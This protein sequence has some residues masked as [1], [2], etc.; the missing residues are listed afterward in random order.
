MTRKRLNIINRISLKKINRVLL[1]LNMKSLDMKKKIFLFMVAAAGLLS[2]H[3]CEFGSSDGTNP[4]VTDNVT[5]SG[6]VVESISGDPIFGATV[7]LTDGEEVVTTTTDVSGTYSLEIYIADD[8]ELSVIAYKSGYSTDTLQ[9]YASAGKPV[10]A[11][12]IQLKQIQGTG[13]TSSGGAATINLYSQSHTSIGVI[14]SGANESAQLIFQV[15][16]S[17]GVAIGSDNSVILNFSLTSGPGGGEYI[18]PSSVRTNALGRA[19]VSLNT[20]TKA[21]VAQITAEMTVNGKSIKSKPIL[22]AIHGGFPDANHFDVACDALNYPLYGIIGAE[23]QFTAFVGDKYS[24]P[25]RPGT[26]VYFSANSGIIEGSDQT[27]DLGRATVTLLTQP[28]PNDATAG[29]GFFRVQ[30]STVNESQ[31]EI[32]ASTLRL[33]SGLTQITGISPGTFDIANGGSQSFT[34]K[35]SDGNGNP[36]AAGTQIR[37]SVKSGDVDVSGDIEIKLP[38]TQSKAFTNFSFTVFDSKPEETKVQNAVIEISVTGPNGDSKAAISG[39][40][41]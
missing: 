40:S 33:L 3:G 31:T 32:S 18:Y 25:V 26:S 30:A 2:F 29:P 37:V 4:D 11:P 27:D 15:L 23:I 41:R 12:I 6:Q 24:N 36:L 38:D 13:G 16:D 21:G 28:F 20:G 34:F 39:T 14:E 10:T 8:K 1:S 35:V 5:V 22:M 19:S 9:F 7:K 17:T